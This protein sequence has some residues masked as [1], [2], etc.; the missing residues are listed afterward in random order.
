MSVSFEQLEKHLTKYNN[1]IKLVKINVQDLEFSTSNALKC[2]Y[3]EK[4]N[5]C[6]MCPPRIPA[7]DYQAIFSEYKNSAILY[8]RFEF[9]KDN[10]N[11]VRVESSVTIHKAVL[12]LESFLLQ[13]NSSTYLSFIGG[14]CKLCKN[15]CGIEKCNN[16]YNARVSMEAVGINVVETL[17]K[18]GIEVSFPVKNDMIRVGMILW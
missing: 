16:R 14:S 10:Y 17:S 8:S 6:W 11:S 7:L 12:N 1:E 2:F 4:Y 3:C 5:T 15:G 9:D 13:N 18:F